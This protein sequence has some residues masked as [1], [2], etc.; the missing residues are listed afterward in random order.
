MPVLTFPDGNQKSFA[1]GVTGRDVAESIS[2]SLAKK[3]VA[4]K[5]DGVLSDLSDE[6]AGDAGMARGTARSDGKG[7]TVIEVTSGRGRGVTPEDGCDR[8][9]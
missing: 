4:M 6:V 7:R 9:G 1:A 3:A 2:R 8:M 5:I